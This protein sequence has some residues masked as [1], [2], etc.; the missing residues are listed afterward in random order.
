VAPQALYVRHSRTW[1]LCGSQAV[2]DFNQVHCKDE[3]SW[4]S[5]YSLDIAG[6]QFLSS[7]LHHFQMVF[8]P[9]LFGDAL[10]E[11]CT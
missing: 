10:E 4:G 1:E 3:H 11:N 5:K 7:F 2:H 8:M 6:C 9:M